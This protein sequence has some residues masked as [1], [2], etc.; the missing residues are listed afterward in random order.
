LLVEAADRLL[1]MR[2][3]EELD[4][5]EAAWPTGFSIDGKDNL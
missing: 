2:A 4:E 1:G 5:R 3:V